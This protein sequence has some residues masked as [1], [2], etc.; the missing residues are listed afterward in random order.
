MRE[1]RLVPVLRKFFLLGRE[2]VVVKLDLDAESLLR[3][4]C[5]IADVDMLDIM[6]INHLFQ[7][8][9]NPRSRGIKARCYLKRGYRG[10]AF[11]RNGEHLGDLW[12]VQPDP[13]FRGVRHPDLRCLRIRLSPDSAYGFD[14]FLQPA[15][16][17]KGLAAPLMAAGFSRLRDAGIKTMVGFYDA[18]NLPALWMHKM[19]SFQEID[20][21][22]V[23]GVLSWKWSVASKPKQFR[24]HREKNGAKRSPGPKTRLGAAH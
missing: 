4:K 15:F 8:S 12:F 18:D 16:R 5:R 11:V 20:R 24:F 3:M 23:Y 19:L 7:V 21:R 14:M 2:Q 9:W 6:R 1:G 13:D 22:K 17:G 10:I